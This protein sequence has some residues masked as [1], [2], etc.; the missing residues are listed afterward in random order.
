M[1]YKVAEHLL[2]KNA[3]QMVKMRI[4]EEKRGGGGRREEEAQEDFF[5]KMSNIYKRSA[6][7]TTPGE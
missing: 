6:G 1:F 3:M 7:V 5:G 2:K 4:E